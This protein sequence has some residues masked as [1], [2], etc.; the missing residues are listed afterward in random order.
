MELTR[1]NYLNGDI[2]KLDV[3]DIDTFYENNYSS[4]LSNS[5]VESFLKALKIPVKY[6]LKQPYDTR[7]ELLQNQKNS[8]A[9][10]KC[11]IMLVRKNVIDYVTL[12]DDSFIDDRIEVTP[13]NSSWVFL[14]EDLTSG[15]IRFFMPT[16]D[17]VEDEY[18]LGV[19]IDYPILFSKPMIINTGFYK[20]SKQDTSLNHELMI[21][22]TKIKLKNTELPN[23]EHNSYF[24]DLIDAVKKENF[25]SV[26]KYLEKVNVDT[27]SCVTLL[28]SFEKDKLINKSTSKKIR[29]YIDK[30][31]LVLTSLFEL[32]NLM[33]L[34]VNDPK[35]YSA[36][37][38]YKTDILSSLLSVH[39]KLPKVSYILDFKEGY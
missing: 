25:D 34:F 27:T 13:I 18:N 1:K 37:L 7:I 5:G 26:L 16:K 22:N 20:I 39:N 29:K 21:P 6:F 38:K 19:F 4:N 17:I 10:D 35:S 23:T 14:E 30:E 31:D 32:T 28:L 9:N 36:R 8:M 24:L 33:T 2:Y 11:L 12:N 3:E 15:Y